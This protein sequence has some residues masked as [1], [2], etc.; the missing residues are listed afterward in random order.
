MQERDGG[1]QGGPAQGL[2]HGVVIY[3]VS[4]LLTLPLFLVIYPHVPAM[5]LPIG[6]GLRV[7]HI[8]TFLAVLVAMVVLV[9]KFQL[10]VYLLLVLGLGALT[11]T[12]L[13]GRYGLRDV[14]RDYGIM[15]NSL[16]GNT[17]S[18]PLTMAELRPFQDADVI[19][20]RIDYQDPLVRR[21][22]VKAATTWF[23]DKVTNDDYEL[24]QDFSV[25]KVINGSWRYVNDV[26]GGEYFAPA[27]ESISL[28]AGDC[29][30]HAILM[31]A[32]LKAIGAE[33]RLVR[34]TGHIYPELKVGD[35]KAMERAAYL[36]RE[37]LFPEEAAHA[38][39]YYHTD[40]NG[41]RWI[42]LDYTRHYPGGEVMDE[43]IKGILPV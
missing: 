31:A 33:V 25:F 30:D 12:S 17:R 22:A 10:A 8:V 36:I 2:A 13:T 32:C 5:V 6:D 18:M 43:S 24:V 11:I 39:F 1:E 34:T 3:L 35:A 20:S 19:L 40:A 27:S 37:E 29:D 38:P 26:R 4:L 42:N 14:E 28:L 7:D 41:D 21:F 16:R 23:A 9:R 15:L